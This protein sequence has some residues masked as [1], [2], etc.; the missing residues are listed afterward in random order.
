MFKYSQY[1]LDSLLAENGNRV[2]DLELI[3]YE[4]A[5]AYSIITKQAFL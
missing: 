1:A 3:I 4:F 2:D 5:G